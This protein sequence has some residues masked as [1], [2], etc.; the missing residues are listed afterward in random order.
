MVWNEVQEMIGKY[1]LFGKEVKITQEDVEKY[2][3]EL[4]NWTRLNDVLSDITREEV[5]LKMLVME[6]LSKARTD[7]LR[8]VHSRLVAVRKEHERKELKL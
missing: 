1:K 7:I 3:P 5:L 6:Q 2:E 8:R 4:S